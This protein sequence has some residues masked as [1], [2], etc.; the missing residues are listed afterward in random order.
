LKTAFGLFSTEHGEMIVNRFDYNHT[1]EG[2]WYGVGAQLLETGAY[3]SGEITLLKQLLTE[4]RKAVGDP[5]TV[6]DCGANIGVFT[7]EIARLMR[8]WGTVIAIEPQ[9]RLFYALAGNIALNNAFNARAIW[10]AVDAQE[11]FLDI[12]QPDYC[13]PGSFGSFELQRA[14]DTEDIGQA[15][16]YDKPTSHVRTMKID[17]LDCGRID[18]VKL[19][20]E[21]MELDALGGAI[22]VLKRDR[23]ILC[24]EVIKIDRDAL[25]SFLQ[26]LGYKLF[27]HNAMNAIAV[28]T[29]DPTICCIVVE[30]QAA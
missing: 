2:K 21:G 28:H 1:Y 19:D 8:G 22:A 10:A 27:V 17:D 9:E 25:E 29:N 4:K 20:I 23:P 30:Q 12:P 3:E 24:I 26:S 15:I 7:L 16:D 11:G 18:L 13:Q 5:V 6:L 14:I